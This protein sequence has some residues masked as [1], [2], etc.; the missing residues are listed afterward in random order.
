MST[1]C[2]KVKTAGDAGI[3][4]LCRS[5]GLMIPGV[6]VSNGQSWCCVYQRWETVSARTFVA[7]VREVFCWLGGDIGEN[8]LLVMDG[9]P[10]HNVTQAV[11]TRLMGEVGGG[12]LGKQD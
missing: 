7:T 2:P 5:E 9:A 12:L 6:F 10:V 3:N 4:A 11:M 1:Q 8:S